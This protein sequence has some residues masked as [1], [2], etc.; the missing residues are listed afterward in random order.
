MALLY[1]T[2]DKS[3]PSDK[4]K[5]FF[6]SHPQDWDT[7]FLPV[8]EELFQFCNCAVYYDDPKDPTPRDIDYYAQLRQMHLFVVPVTSAFLSRP[9]T[10]LD[11]DFRYAQEHHIPVLPLVQES[12]LDKLFAQKCGNLQYLDKVLRSPTAI[13]YDVK[14][15]QFLDAVLLGNEQVDRIRSHFDGHIFLSYRKKDRRHIQSMMRLIHQFPQFRDIGLWYDEYLTPGEDFNDEIKA[16]LNQS[17]LFALIVTPNLVNEDNYVKEHEY[18]M[19]QECHKPILPVQFEPTDASALRAGYPQIPDCLNTEDRD[20]LESA[21]EH[22]LAG[23]IKRNNDSDPDH[24]Y[25]IGLAYLTGTDVE[26]NRELAIHLITQAAESGLEEAMEKLTKMYRTGDG[27]PRDPEQV[28]FWTQKLVGLT[29]ARYH[30]SSSR[31]DALLYCIQLGLAAADCTFIDRYDLARDYCLRQVAL[32]KE[33][34]DVG[35]CDHTQ[36]IAAHNML[37]CIYDAQGYENEAAEQLYAAYRLLHSVCKDSG[38]ASAEQ[39]GELSR[40]CQG[41]GDLYQDLQHMSHAERFYR[42]AIK[43]LNTLDDEDLSLLHRVR[44]AEL[45]QCLGDVFLLQED[46][47]NAEKEYL[48]ALNMAKV[49]AA[50]AGDDRIL[51]AHYQNLGKLGDQRPG[52]GSGRTYLKKALELAQARDARK[53]TDETQI[54]LAECCAML[55]FSYYTN[56]ALRLRNVIRGQA[57]PLLEQSLSIFRDVHLRQSTYTSQLRVHGA[58]CGLSELHINMDFFREAESYCAEQLAI[59]EALL[60]QSND[61]E[62][63]IRLAYDLALMTKICKE[64]KKTVT[65]ARYAR[66]RFDLLDAIAEEINTCEIWNEL[67]EASFDWALLTGNRKKLNYAI[68]IW[69]F[70]AQEHPEISIYSQREQEAREYLPE[71]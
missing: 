58:L 27:V 47:D 63:T 57:K 14:L 39:L 42:Q 50:E 43:L 31:E 45:H 26:V 9:N 55:G 23:L 29:H 70:L 52:L 44:L 36:L 22:T 40:I 19:A 61:P 34:Y 2:K 64:L 15:Q 48:T 49:I 21:L 25:H 12:G 59:S 33:L 37:S 60:A 8:C 56:W 68:E 6:T 41:I 13:P 66:R 18:P 5:V 32:A 53:R 20:T 46:F 65:A 16:H 62:S 7:Y 3:H 24:L 38:K 17:H 28:I 54:D 35:A 69:H 1:R 10:A 51:I 71:S 30:S 4:P 11:H 67:A